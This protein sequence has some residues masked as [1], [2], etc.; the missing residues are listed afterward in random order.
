LRFRLEDAMLPN[1]RKPVQP[2]E[3]LF[4]E[5]LN[6]LGIS[7]VEL[8]GRIGEP[9]RYV[10]SLI[11]GKRRLTGRMANLLAR[12]LKTSPEFWMAIQV[13][14]DLYDARESLKA[15]G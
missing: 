6:P 1:N 3:I 11:K 5:F 15:S 4:E 2:G 9:V 7:R 14:C 12:A 8:A 10:D 13:A